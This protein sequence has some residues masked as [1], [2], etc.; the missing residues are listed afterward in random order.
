MLDVL[1]ILDVLTCSS[2]EPSP[3]TR[4][5][6]ADPAPGPAAEPRHRDRLTAAAARSR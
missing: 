6:R 4:R 2:R 3:P 5:Q 1:P